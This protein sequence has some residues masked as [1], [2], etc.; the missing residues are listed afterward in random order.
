[1]FICI[2]TLTWIFA[3]S[4]LVA[5]GDQLKYYSSTGLSVVYGDAESQRVIVISNTV[6]WVWIPAWSY[7]W[8]NQLTPPPKKKLLVGML[9]FKHVSP[10][11]IQLLQF[12]AYMICVGNKALNCMLLYILLIG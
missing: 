9:G 6:W 1:M 4:L 7:L 11:L 3:V 10:L 8:S 12:N 5:W 2:G